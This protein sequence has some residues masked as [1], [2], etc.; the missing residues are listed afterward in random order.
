MSFNCAF[1]LAP[2]NR[3]Y[4]MQAYFTV[5]IESATQA[6]ASLNADF[7]VFVMCDSA[8]EFNG[9]ATRDITA[10]AA[11]T[12]A[13]ELLASMIRDRLY[14]AEITSSSEVSVSVR[15]THVDRVTFTGGFAP[16]DRL[17]IDTR[18]QTVTL[19]GV[20]ALHLVD[21]DFFNLI[22][23]PN[24]ITYADAGANRNILTRITH[25]DRYL[26]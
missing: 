17:V 19:N 25:R 10:T 16:G 14:A 22:F 21:G 26:Y 18:N 24:A 8:T 5:S 9:A 7:A 3:P 1:N 13:T 4:V 11:F 2:F 12:S 20:N 23:G 15:Y 6:A